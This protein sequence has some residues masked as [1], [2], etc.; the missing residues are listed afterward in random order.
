MPIYFGILAL[1]I[2][3]FWKIYVKAEQPGWACII[4][5]YNIYILL[6]IVCRP[7]WWLFLYIIPIV[8][9]IVIIT[10]TLDLAKR[11]NQEI[12]FG[13]GLILLPIIFYP[14]LGFGDARYTQCD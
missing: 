4:P 13:I 12:L 5:I 10:V 8:N 2:A 1:F 3:S 9:I 7:S 6:K 11:F 14:I